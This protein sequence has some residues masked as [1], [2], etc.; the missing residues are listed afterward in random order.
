MCC[1]AASLKVQDGLLPTSKGTLLQRSQS[2]VPPFT[3][4]EAIQSATSPYIAKLAMHALSHA[5]DLT[6]LRSSQTPRHITLQTAVCEESHPHRPLAVTR[7][8]VEDFDQS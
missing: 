3:L 6:F 5:H 4:L 2:S 8:F 1:F 7:Q